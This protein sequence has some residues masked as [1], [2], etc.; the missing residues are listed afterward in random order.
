MTKFNVNMTTVVLIW[1]ALAIPL[2]RVVGQQLLWGKYKKSS[3]NDDLDVG[4]EAPRI[5]PNL[6][7]K[8]IRETDIQTTKID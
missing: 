8:A 4:F 2:S 7:T 5:H 6:R 1:F 3:P